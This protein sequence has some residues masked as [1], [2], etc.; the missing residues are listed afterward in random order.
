MVLT[1]YV[2]NATLLATSN[3]WNVAPATPTTTNMQIG[4]SSTQAVTGLATDPSTGVLYGQTSTNSTTPN[5][6]CTIDT[7]TGAATTIGSSGTEPLSDITFREFPAGTWTMWGVGALTSFL[8]TVDLATGA[9]TRQFPL[10]TYS[11]GGLAWRAVD[12]TFINIRP[13]SSVVDFINASTGALSVGPVLTYSGGSSGADH[14]KALSFN[15]TLGG[16][17]YG[18]IGGGAGTVADLVTINTLNGSATFMGQMGVAPAQLASADSLISTQTVCIHGSSR[19]SRLN[20]QSVPVSELRKGDAILG[21]DGADSVAV[22]VLPCWLKTPHMV[23]YHQ[24]VVF[25]K[26]SL[27][28]EEN[29]PNDR[30]VVDAGHPICV[31][32]QFRLHG[33]AALKEARKFLPTPLSTRLEHAP[34]SKPQIYYSDWDAVQSLVCGAQRRYDIVM[35]KGSCGAY[36]ANGVVVQARHSLATPGYRP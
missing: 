33:K 23:D 24:C 36:L 25:E 12:D 19:I 30:F 6:L 35:P 8:F 3:L 16:T 10:M 34:V 29:V 28:A 1:F 5:S 27:S 32:A 11:Q 2:M 4:T 7:G 18:I 21:A 15:T 22:Q 31:P 17:L 9:R 26:G 20:T 14:V 13:T